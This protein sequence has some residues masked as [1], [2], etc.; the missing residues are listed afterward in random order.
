MIALERAGAEHVHVDAELVD[1]VLQEHAVVAEAVDVDQPHRIEIDL[2]GLRGE[3]VLGLIERIGGHHHALAG[4]AKIAQGGA[5]LLQLRQPRGIQIAEIR[6]TINLMRESA[7]AAAMA[8]ITSLSRVSGA[9][10]PEA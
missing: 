6:A 5:D 10:P 4:G 8:S 3:V 7:F 9:G 2:A 1:G